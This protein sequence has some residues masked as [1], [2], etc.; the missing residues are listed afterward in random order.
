MRGQTRGGDRPAFVA[1]PFLGTPPVPPRV[2]ER[3][4]V[5]TSRVVLC[6]SVTVAR[7]WGACA[8]GRHARGVGCWGWCTGRLFGGPSAACGPRVTFCGAVIV[9]R[10]GDTDTRVA[11]RV[12]SG[13]D[14]DT[15]G[16][17]TAVAIGVASP[18]RVSPTVTTGV[19]RPVTRGFGGFRAAGKTA[20]ARLGGTEERGQAWGGEQTSCRCNSCRADCPAAAAAA[21]ERVRRQLRPSTRSTRGADRVTGAPSRWLKRALRRR[22]LGWS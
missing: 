2:A 1:T 18:A 17:A 14:G 15:T 6:V 22:A 12:A 16:V 9:S 7:R 4:A 13:L 5:I 19:A 11:V 20:A 8:A 10:T 3:P 21:A